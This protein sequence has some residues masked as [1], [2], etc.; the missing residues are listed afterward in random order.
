MTRDPICGMEVDE[1]TDRYKTDYNGKTY[2]FCSTVCLE[3]FQKN[4]SQYLKKR[5]IIARF[6]D[7]VAKGNKKE[8]HD[9]PPSCCGHT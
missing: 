2:L 7:W 5:G 9:T 3:S 6:L 8:F 1:Q 4:P